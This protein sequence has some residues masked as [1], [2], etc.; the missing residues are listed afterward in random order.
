MLLVPS[1]TTLP[2]PSIC[3]SSR[4]ELRSLQIAA[5]MFGENSRSKN[6]D[7]DQNAKS[8]MGLCTPWKSDK[9]SLKRSTSKNLFALSHSPNLCV[10]SRCVFKLSSGGSKASTPQQDSG[11]NV[12]EISKECL[13]RPAQDQISRFKCLNSK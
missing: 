7:S 10:C 12:S 3:L 9:C 6:G 8:H 1:V 5:R 2:K 4:K 11:C 13:S